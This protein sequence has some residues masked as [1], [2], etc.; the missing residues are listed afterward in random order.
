MSAVKLA[1]KRL[2]MTQKEFTLWLNKTTA[3]RS[4]ISVPQV[5]RWENGVIAARKD[6]K[7]ICEPLATLHAIDQINVVCGGLTP[8]QELLIGAVIKEV[9]V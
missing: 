1:R 7:E 6:V 2:N 8:Q 3:R 9:Q 4:T 5:S